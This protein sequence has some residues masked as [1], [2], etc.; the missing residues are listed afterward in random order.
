VAQGLQLPFLTP[1]LLVRL[2]HHS[3]PEVTPNK[4]SV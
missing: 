3:V 1:S 4:I 2:H